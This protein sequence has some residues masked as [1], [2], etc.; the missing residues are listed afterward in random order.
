[1]IPYRQLSLAEIFE[2]CQDKFEMEL[3]R[4]RYKET[5]IYKHAKL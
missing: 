1:M 3:I 5:S 4:N 2:D